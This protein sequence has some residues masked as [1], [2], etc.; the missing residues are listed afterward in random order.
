MS[1]PAQQQPAIDG[2]QSSFDETQHV[3]NMP[4]LNVNQQLAVALATIQ[5]IQLQMQGIQDGF[6]NLKNDMTVGFN[7]LKRLY[8][9]QFNNG[10]AIAGLNGDL[11]GSQGS[12]PPNL[13]TLSEI[14]CA[15][16]EN[17]T[18]FCVAGC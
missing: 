2:A 3:A 15:T 10:L 16:G 5:G 17:G 1:Q 4:L 9:M 14:A 11:Q 18:G 13:H 7:R 12:L 8:T 6:Q